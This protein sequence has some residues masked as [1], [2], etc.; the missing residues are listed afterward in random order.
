MGRGEVQ[1]KDNIREGEK[2]RGDTVEGIVPHFYGE[3]SSEKEINSDRN[4]WNL[5]AF[6]DIS[7]QHRLCGRF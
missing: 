5:Y 1:H 2:G 7:Q 6:F 4:C 3:L